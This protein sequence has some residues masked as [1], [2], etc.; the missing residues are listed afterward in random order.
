MTRFVQAEYPVQHAGVTRV[1]RGL[2]VLA[3]LNITRATLH[4]LAFIGSP[5]TRLAGKA[6]SRLAALAAKRRQGRADQKLWNIALQDAR[7]MADLS[8][9]MSQEASR[10]PRYS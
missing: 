3:Q 7:V 1:T 8:R 2:E 10:T 9:A 4:L 5:V 6:R